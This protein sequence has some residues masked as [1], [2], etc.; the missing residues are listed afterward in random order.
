MDALVRPIILIDGEVIFYG[1]IGIFPFIEDVTAERW[2]V[3]K[4]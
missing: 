2:S 4:I 1:K 3:N